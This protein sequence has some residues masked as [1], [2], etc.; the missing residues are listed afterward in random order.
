MAGLSRGKE[1]SEIR[2]TGAEGETDYDESLRQIGWVEWGRSFLL[3]YISTY[4]IFLF[5]SLGPQRL[6]YLLPGKALIYRTQQEL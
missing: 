1:C 3:R 5:L 2:A 6:K 4:I